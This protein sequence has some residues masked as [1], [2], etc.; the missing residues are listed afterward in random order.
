[1]SAFPYFLLMLPQLDAKT[2]AVRCNRVRVS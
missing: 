1:M 2:H